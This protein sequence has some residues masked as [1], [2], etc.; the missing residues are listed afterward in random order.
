MPFTQKFFAHQKNLTYKII[1]LIACSL[2]SITLITQA[3]ESDEW[4]RFRGPNGS[5]LSYATTIPAEFT[6]SDFNWKT[7]L[8]GI[9]HSSPVIWQDHIYLLVANPEKEGDRSLVCYSTKNGK[10]LWSVADPYKIHH[11]NKKLNTFASCTPVTAVEGVYFIS[12]TGE[13]LSIRAVTH[14]GKE[15]WKQQLDAYTSDHGSASS[16]ILVNGVIIVNTDSKEKRE[17]HIVGIDAPSGKILWSRER[18]DPDS[19]KLPHKTV[20]STPLIV[21]LG[22]KKSVALVSTHHGWLGLDPKTGK[23]LWQHQENYPNRS[24]GSPVEKDGLVF[25]TLGASGKGK[26]SDAFRVGVTGKVEVLY[27]LDKTGGLGY[28]PT[29]L[30]IDDL[31]YLWSDKGMLTCREA[32]SGKEVYSEKVGGVYFSSPI[33]INGR[34]YCA[35]RDG[36]MAVIQA[37]RKFKVLSR[38]DFDSDIFATPAIANGQLIV[39]TKTHLISIGGTAK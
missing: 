13:N 27:S 26:L 9:G 21:M 25:A 10:E 29:P 22:D 24:V 1:T 36:I 4:T 14:D 11:T 3:A 39:R 8:K 6:E 28:V 34:I 19:E 18:V 15:R 20:Y 7:E 30:F 31:L 23:T 2:I 16:P 32:L 38:H 35:T 33:A 37:G 12:S 17:N 5:G